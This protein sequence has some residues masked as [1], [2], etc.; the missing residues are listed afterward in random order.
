MSCYAVQET[1]PRFY[2]FIYLHQ[3]RPTEEQEK[4]G[5]GPNEIT[6]F[7]LGGGVAEFMWWL[8][9]GFTT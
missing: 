8:N 7:K 3:Q 2:V 1:D 9:R 6:S 4:E 5:V